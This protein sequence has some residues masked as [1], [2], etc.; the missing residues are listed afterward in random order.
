M[1]ELWS[2]FRKEVQLSY[3]KGSRLQAIVLIP[4]KE[5]NKNKNKGR[6]WEAFA[7]LKL[8]NWQYTFSSAQF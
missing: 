6:N 4:K 5:K 7:E 2:R 3:F 8:N 1:R